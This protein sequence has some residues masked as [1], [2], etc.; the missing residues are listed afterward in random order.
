MADVQEIDWLEQFYDIYPRIEDDFRAAL[1]ESLR[2]RGPEL[3]YELVETFEL[4]PVRLLSTSVAGKGRTRFTS[5]RAFDSASPALT[6]SRGTSSLL[7]RPPAE[8]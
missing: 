6:R 4:P 1:D 3:L 2:P 5:P 8:R 7:P